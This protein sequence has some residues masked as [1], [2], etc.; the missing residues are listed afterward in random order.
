[1]RVAFI[2]TILATCLVAA[3]S[4][5]VA[6]T[7]KPPTSAERLAQLEQWV[8]SAN[9]QL[10][11]LGIDAFSERFT[12]DYVQSRTYDASLAAQTRRFR[13]KVG[14]AIAESLPA[15]TTVASDPLF[16]CPSDGTSE[17]AALAVVAELKSK[18]FAIFWVRN[19]SSAA[20]ICIGHV[21]YV[22][23][24][25]PEPKEVPQHGGGE[26]IINADDI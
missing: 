16:I 2:A 26:T 19:T 22:L 7:P 11:A 25:L 6:A 4:V 17:A 8:Q 12:P 23:V 24:A 14:L 13:A 9:A 18:G 20:S 21:G 3:S 1:M 10:M 5:A 15:T